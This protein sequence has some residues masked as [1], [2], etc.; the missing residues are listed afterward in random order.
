VSCTQAPAQYAGLE[1]PGH[2]IGQSFPA[3]FEGGGNGI[4]N[5]YTGRIH[6]VI[7]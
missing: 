1:V 5:Q 3:G 4:G 7:W 6:I 2:E